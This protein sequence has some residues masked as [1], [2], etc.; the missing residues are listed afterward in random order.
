MVASPP[1]LVIRPLLAATSGYALV[2]LRKRHLEFTHRKRSCN[3]HLVPRPLVGIFVR[4]HHELARREHHH[5][6][7]RVAVL[8][9]VL[10]LQAS[11][12]VTHYRLNNIAPLRPWYWYRPGRDYLWWRHSDRQMLL[13]ELFKAS[14][15]HLGIKRFLKPADI[16]FE[17]CNIG[18]VLCSV[19]RLGR[20]A[21][22][23][24][25]WGCWHSR[26]RRFSLSSEKHAFSALDAVL[27][28]G[29]LV[30]VGFIDHCHAHVMEHNQ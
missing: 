15:C 25:R 7:T 3:R 29:H 26:R 18:R 28:P 12:F 10:R 5:L 17:Q 14:S 9:A 6:G 2:P 30:A 27:G 13:L 22:S 23:C 4:A 1:S 16:R 11:P 8:E 19:P 21:Q 24:W 20:L